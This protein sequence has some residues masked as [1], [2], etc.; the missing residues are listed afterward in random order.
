[1]EGWVAASSGPA[2]VLKAALCL[3]GGWEISRGLGR[4]G[5]GPGGQ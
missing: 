2:L 1:M 4:N 5:G 3:L